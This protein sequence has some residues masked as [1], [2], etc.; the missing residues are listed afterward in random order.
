VHGGANPSS[1]VGHVVVD[2][3]GVVFCN[4]ESKSASYTPTRSLLAH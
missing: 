2:V 4:L 3:E 1:E